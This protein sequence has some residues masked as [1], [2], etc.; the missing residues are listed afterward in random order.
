MDLGTTE[1]AVYVSG[2]P[3]AQAGAPQRLKHSAPLKQYLFGI[4]TTGVYAS[5]FGCLKNPRLMNASKKLLEEV[6]QTDG[7]RNALRYHDELCQRNNRFYYHDLKSRF[8]VMQ[9]TNLE[10][11]A[12]V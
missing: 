10:D 11:A 1:D 3:K 9:M 5:T 12:E 6:I 4:H 8:P 7:R 2:L